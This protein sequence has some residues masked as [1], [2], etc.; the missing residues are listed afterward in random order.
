VTIGNERKAGFVL[1]SSRLVVCELG[2]C[3]LVGDELAMAMA[4]K[5]CTNGVNIFYRF[6]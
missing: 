2:C 5:L 3:C 1:G 4:M 6:R